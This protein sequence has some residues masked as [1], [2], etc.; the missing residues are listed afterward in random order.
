M[1]SALGVC[2]GG[3]LTEVIILRS[4]LDKPAH[5]IGLFGFHFLV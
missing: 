3:F 4:M 5:K 1:V 2:R